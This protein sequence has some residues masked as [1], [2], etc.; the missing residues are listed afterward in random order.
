MVSFFNFLDRAFDALAHAFDDRPP[1]ERP[2]SYPQVVMFL[3]ALALVPCVLFLGWEGSPWLLGL[4]GLM[5]AIIM[6]ALY[7]IWT[8]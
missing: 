2:R 8:R 5:G 4:L 3:L 7:P 1:S 6:A